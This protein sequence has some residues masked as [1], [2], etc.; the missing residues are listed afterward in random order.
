MFFFLTAPFFEQ[1]VLDV[2]CG[3]GILSLFAARAG[4]R[5]V[6][7]VDCA[8]IAQL[9]AQVI[10]K[11]HFA[12]VIK[13]FQAKIED[14]ELPV[15]HVDVIISE[16]MGYCLLFE[17]MLDSVLFARDKWLRPGGLLMPDHC[18]LFMS[19]IA[20]RDQ[21]A[22]AI[23]YWSNVAGEFDMSAMRGQS[24]AEGR[25]M[26]VNEQ[27]VA[28][29][30]FQLK[31]FNLHKVRREE[32]TLSVPFRLKMSRDDMLYGL[33]THFTVEFRYS[34]AVETETS[35]YL[36]VMRFTAQMLPSS[37]HAVHIAAGAADALETNGVLLP[38]GD[39]CERGRARVRHFPTGPEQSV[40]SDHGHYAGRRLSRRLRDDPV[41]Q[42]EVLCAIECRPA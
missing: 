19:G 31:R 21:H 8:D 38:R 16:W 30:V 29:D 40:P 2:G 24:L 32:L 26:Q 34:C 9:A 42:A 11:N 23:E 10:E 1:V 18:A 36:N 14:V 41:E 25:V 7:A 6:L 20:C 17:S 39:H 12:H 4:A 35:L 22:N 5:L 33:A 27:E 3:T 37:D 28:T 15:T 13:V